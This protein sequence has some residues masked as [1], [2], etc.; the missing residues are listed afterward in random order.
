MGECDE[1]DRQGITKMPTGIEGVDEITG[2]GL[3]RC[4]TTLVIGGPGSG[5]TVFALETLV[6]GARE[7]GEPGIFVAFEENTRHI[8]QNAAS[9]GWDLPALEREKLFFLDARFPAETVLAGGYDLVG[10][11][12]SIDA[13][14]KAMGAKRIVFDSID[15]LL[16][17]MDDPRAERTELYRLHDWLSSGELTGIVTTRIE[18]ADQRHAEDY[19]FLQFMADAVVKLTH[20]VEDRISTRGFRVVKYRGS[21]YA[22]NEFPLVISE[23][24][25]EVA[26][27]GIA[28]RELDYPV[29]T[30]R[31]STGV[32]RLDAMFSGGYFR[33]TSMLVTGAP[34]TAKS[35]L[36]G[37]FTQAACERGERALY[38]SFDEVPQEIV[39][40]LASVNIRLA[41]HVE[42][43]LL[44]MESYRTEARGAEEHLMRMRALIREH[45]PRCMVI[46]PLSAVVKSGGPIAAFTVAIRLLNL[47]KQRGITLF[48]TSLVEGMEPMAEATPLH[49]STIADTWIHLSYVVQ[50]GERNR[51]LTIVKSRG[52][53]HSAQV[54]ELVLSSEGV[55]LTNVYTAGGAVLMGTLRREREQQDAFARRQAEQ[56]MARKQREFELAEAESQARITAAQREL[57]VKRSELELMRHQFQAREEQ[58]ETQMKERQHLRGADIPGTA[59]PLSEAIPPEERDEREGEGGAG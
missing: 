33:G 58:L 23:R 37:A 26:S 15:V 44:R 4:R 13:K 21:A 3:P 50:G 9:F 34:G 32:E 43:G 2:G 35:T 28:G 1:Q 24:G 36:A 20:E 7:W 31:I 40:N 48:S 6:N 57:E 55:S 17:I 49:I 30:E 42:S 25:L 47:A 10:M 59:P 19:G 12:A 14:A 41:P 52:T 11:L 29:S 54:R 56:E 39:R 51:A 46:D 38:V 53:K 18:G 8:V 45:E 16:S 27:V 5:K 22:E